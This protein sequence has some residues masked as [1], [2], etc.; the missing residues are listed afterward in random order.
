MH[1]DDDDDAGAKTKDTS[2]RNLFGTSPESIN[3]RLAGDFVDESREV[4]VIITEAVGATM[5]AGATEAAD[6]TMAPAVDEEVDMFG[7]F[8]DDVGDDVLT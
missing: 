2:T 8:G 7:R 4:P 6:V 5:A 1:A 3:A